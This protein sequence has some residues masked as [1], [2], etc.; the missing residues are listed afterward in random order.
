MILLSMVGIYFI[1]RMFGKFVHRKL[2]HP[3]RKCKDKEGRTSVKVNS[4]Q[5]C[6]MLILF[7]YLL[8]AKAS[9]AIFAC[10]HIFDQYVT[11]TNYS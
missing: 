10:V 11:S 9:L 6:I 8:I 7:S 4:L 1:S 3:E 2:K 5:A